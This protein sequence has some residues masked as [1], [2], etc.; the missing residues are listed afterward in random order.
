[1]SRTAPGA[2][3]AWSLLAVGALAPCALLALHASPLRQFRTVEIALFALGGV[4]GLA[5]LAVHRGF[6]PRGRW[7]LWVILA[8]A[9]VARLAFVGHEPSNDVYRYLWEGRIQHHGVN[10]YATP[11]SDPSLVHLRDANHGRINHP[12]W[13]AIYGPAAQALFAATTRV[14]SSPGV[15]KAVVLCFDFAAI[16]LLTALLRTVGRSPLWVVGYA[17]N[18]LV[19]WSFAGAAHVDAVVIVALLAALLALER[20]RAILAG[21]ALG[22]GV[23]V[24]A[25]LLVLLPLLWRPRRRPA[26]L[27]AMVLVVGVGYLPYADAGQGLVESLLRFGTR[28]RFNDLGGLVHAGPMASWGI[29]LAVFAAALVWWWRRGPRPADGATWL[30][31]ASMLAAPT[32]HPWYGA[33]LGACNCVTGS[34]SWFVLTVTLVAALETAARE[35]TTGIWAEPAW[36]RWAVYAPFLAVALVEVARKRWG[37]T[38]G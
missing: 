8:V 38:P 35:A 13:T 3:A 12:E 10:P 31:G 21:V 23:L 6:V 18:P 24:K 28:M 36:V 20:E 1:M 34:A 14:S 2:G 11:P 26:A 30:V 25:T 16:A 5:L 7:S 15:W 17:W 9:L 37:R 33:T 22:A 27:A 19:L 29:S 4:M 32:V